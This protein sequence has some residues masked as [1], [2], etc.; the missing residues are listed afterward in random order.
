MILYLQHTTPFTETHCIDRFKGLKASF[1]HRLAFHEFEKN[2]KKLQ[3]PDARETLSEFSLDQVSQ[4]LH[5][6]Y[7]HFLIRYHCHLSHFEIL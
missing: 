6:E 7:E 2:W 3:L 5:G 1:A 4:Y